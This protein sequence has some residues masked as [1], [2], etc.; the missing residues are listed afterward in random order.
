MFFLRTPNPHTP[1][2]ADPV[3]VRNLED[4]VSL[5][6]YKSCYIQIITQCFSINNAQYL[7]RDTLHTMVENQVFLAA[8]EPSSVKN[9]HKTMTLVY[10]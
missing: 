7:V 10:C 6:S 3:S 4:Q 8:W 2:A 9:N 1:P 5:D